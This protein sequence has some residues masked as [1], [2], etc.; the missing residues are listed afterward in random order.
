MLNSVR[1]DYERAMSW[2]ELALSGMAEPRVMGDLGLYGLGLV[3][4]ARGLV[5]TPLRARTRRLG[6]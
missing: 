3:G 5:A 1:S 6:A 2:F 4:D